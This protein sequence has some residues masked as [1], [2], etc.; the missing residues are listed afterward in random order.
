MDDPQLREPVAESWRRATLAGL[1]PGSAMDRIDTADVDRGSALLA[2]AAPVLDE[3][4]AN[5]SGTKFSTLLVDRDGRVAH[6]WCGD[7][8]T[9]RS[10]DNV[11]VDVGASLLEEVIG[12]NAPGTVLETRRGFAVH[13]SEHFAVAL[14]R[15]SC[16]GHP[17]FHPATRRIEGVLDLSALVEEAHP[18]LPPL[19]AR[20]VQDIEQRLLDRSRVS[21]KRL[22]AAFQTAGNRR[23]PVMAIGQDLQI[24]N[25][26]ALDLIGP[27]DQALLRMLAADLRDLTDVDVTLESGRT[28]RVHATRIG[29]AQGGALLEL[30]PRTPVR[31]SAPTPAPSRPMAPVVVSGPPGSGRTTQ[32]RRIAVQAPL[33]VLT[34]ASAVL[35]GPDAWIRDFGA[36]TRSRQG[37]LIIDG[38]EH[39][40][41][42]VL[43]L[44]AH[45]VASGHAPRVVLV[46]GDPEALTGR[47][48]ALV[49]DCTER[50]AM[51]ALS[52]RMAELSDLVAEMLRTSGADPSLHFTPGAMRA[53]ACHGWP[54]NLRELRA[55]VDAVLTRRSSGGVVVDDLPAVYRSVEPHRP[56]A[57]IEKAEREVIVAALQATDGN[58]VKAAE[59]LGISR[60][61]LYAKMRALRIT[62][63]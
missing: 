50:I 36:I 21:D 55:V 44:V 42:D 38:I 17:I 32:A 6:R 9:R 31:V 54:G 3:L 59:H 39:L 48:A 8:L 27:T 2:A 22:L 35:D 33:T 41:D 63:Y 53:L 56:M 43:S 49:G 46:C 13:G 4:N 30:E 45:H 37:S 18:L 7:H 19:V 10:F 26:A 16:Y 52:L 51:P 40:D 25:Q 62:V 29:G 11:G 14:R 12:T 60:T 1:Q 57:P 5:L 23:R 58:K 15:F 20:A 24:A 34:G 61:T 47:A 28:V